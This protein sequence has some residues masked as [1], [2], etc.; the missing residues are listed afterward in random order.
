MPKRDYSPPSYGYGPA[1]T[2]ATCPMCG[3]ASTT[4]SASCD[5]PSI[6]QLCLD[7]RRASLVKGK[8]TVQFCVGGCCARAGAKEALDSLLGSLR[9]EGV[10]GNVSVVPVDCVDMCEDG[11]VCR[12]LPDR[13]TCRRISPAWA[14]RLGKDLARDRRARK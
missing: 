2:A 13:K 6:A 4:R 7:C 9:E 3:K 5:G 8:L 1:R 14:A 10:L 12:L 11:P